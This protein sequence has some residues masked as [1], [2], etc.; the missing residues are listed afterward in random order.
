MMNST[1]MAK[2][3]H[4]PMSHVRMRFNE[5]A[6]C[7]QTLHTYT[8]PFHA[9]IFSLYTSCLCDRPLNVPFTWKPCKQDGQARWKD[10]I[11]RVQLYHSSLV[12]GHSASFSQFLPSTSMILRVSIHQPSVAVLSRRTV[13]HL[14]NSHMFPL[15]QEQRFLYTLHSQTVGST[16]D[17]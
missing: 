10:G 7:S 8:Y 15:S 1:G 16:S 14:L 2:S 12:L 5:Q 3:Q 4:Y 6:H 13:H 9:Q 17:R 11:P